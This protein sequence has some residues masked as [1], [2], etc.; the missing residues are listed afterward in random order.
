MPTL[1]QASGTVSRLLGKYWS[2][3]SS[4]TKKEFAKHLT[5][6]SSVGSA[7]V[8]KLAN[9]YIL[10]LILLGKQ[11]GTRVNQTYMSMVDCE[12]EFQNF[13]WGSVS[14][15]ATIESFKK[16]LKNPGADQL[17][18]GGFPHALIVWAF[19]TI[20]LIA[21]QGYT[22]LVNSNT[23]P[24]ML[25]WLSTAQPSGDNLEMNIFRNESVSTHY[26]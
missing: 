9:L 18:F 22:T 2:G 23:Y 8:T 11:D 17:Y 16:L 19:E 21:A 6:V 4:L 1:V 13:P 25:K 3:K 7:D 24:R 14:Y 20:P 12:D 15:M 10:E 5:T 26:I